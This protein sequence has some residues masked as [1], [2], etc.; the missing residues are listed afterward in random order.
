MEK[1][2]GYGHPHFLHNSLCFAVSFVL[3]WDILGSKHVLVKS[4]QGLSFLFTVFNWFQMFS[5][6]FFDFH[7][8]IIILPKS[9]VI[10]LFLKIRKGLKEF[11]N[12]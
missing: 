3:S 12:V 4:F 8:F 6:M 2:I 10:Q 9:L 7:V 11:E 1:D 5:N